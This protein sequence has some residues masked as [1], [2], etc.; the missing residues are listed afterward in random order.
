MAIK[1]RDITKKVPKGAI[2]LLTGRA[3][4]KTRKLKRKLSD[5]Y[6]IGSNKGASLN[7]EV[8]PNYEGETHGIAGIILKLPKEIQTFLHNANIK[9]AKVS[10]IESL[11]ELDNGFSL[12]IKDTTLGGRNKQHIIIKQKRKIILDIYV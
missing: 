4:K 6:V 7:V 2:N 8:S 9:K 5:N 3:V 10:S 11:Y 12:K 1:F